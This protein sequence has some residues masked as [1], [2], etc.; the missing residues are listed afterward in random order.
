M[1]SKFYKM[2]LLVG[3]GSVVGV[4]LLLQMYRFAVGPQGVEISFPTLS[5]VS[6]TSS[7]ENAQCIECHQNESPG[8]LDQYHDGK[9]SQRGVQCLDCHKPLEGQEKMTTV[10]YEVQMV[11]APTPNNCAQ[12]HDEAVHEFSIS[13]HAAKSWY[14]VV[15]A[16]D[17]TKEELA[18]YHLLGEDGKP[19]NNGKPNVIRDVIGKDASALSCEACHGIGKKNDDGSFGDCR[20]CH[21]GHDFSIEQARQPETCGQCHLGPDHPQ[22]EIYNESAHGTYYAANKEK[23]NLGAPTGT[24]TT[25]DFPSPTCTT[26]HMSGIGDI[27]PTH[28]VSERLKWN[29]APPIATIRADGGQ[30]RQTMESI[31]LNCHAQGTIDEHMTQAEKIIDLTN[32]NVRKGQSI[33]NELRTIGLLPG[34][35]MSTPIEYLEFELWHHEG[36]RARFGAI[37]SGADYVNWHGIYEQEKALVEI[38]AEAEEMKKD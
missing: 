21:L 19:L 17:F 3:L 14:P 32:E 33:V 6:L 23:F 1:H 27:E 24:L 35:T 28:N 13:A 4:I 2:L 30:N 25:K 20:A 12:C 7:P 5:Q 29:L 36:R 11:A 26:C 10:H 34:S 22:M 18:K 8:I 37:M 16:E 31:C 9:H 15:G 38:K